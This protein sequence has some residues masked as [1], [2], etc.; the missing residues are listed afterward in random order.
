LLAL[1]FS[2]CIEKDFYAKLPIRAVP[3]P[4]GARG[5]EQFSCPMFEPKVFREQM[6]CIEKV[7]VTLLGLFGAPVVVPRPENCAPL[8]TPLLPMRI[9]T[10]MVTSK[11]D[12]VSV[13][14]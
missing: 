12:I 13:I 5:K 9:D 4:D 10:Y 2:R 1:I 3:R 7:L 6:H 8:V 11:A 14:R